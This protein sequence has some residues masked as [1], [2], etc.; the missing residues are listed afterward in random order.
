MKI[1]ATLPQNYAIA[2]FRKNQMTIENIKYL[3]MTRFL[4]S[5]AR[6]CHNKR[7]SVIVCAHGKYIYM[8]TANG[9]VHNLP[10][11]STLKICSVLK[12]D[13]L[14]IY[15]FVNSKKKLVV[16]LFTSS[17][18]HQNQT[19]GSLMTDRFSNICNRN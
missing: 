17:Q 10:L 12:K 6:C 18:R 16:T 13:I 11:I 3:R 2:T 7:S 14:N 5:L 8:V 1:V 15:P 9:T 4:R 19:L